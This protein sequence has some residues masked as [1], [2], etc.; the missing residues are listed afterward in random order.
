MKSKL[1]RLHNINHAAYRCRDAEQTRWFYQEVLGL[2]M[3]I[4]VVEDTV[5]GEGQGAET[6]FMH[7]FFELGDNN[8]VAFFD[9]P[10]TAT[11]EDFK[12]VHSFDRHIAYEVGSREE[13]LAWAKHI[14]EHGVEVFG[15]HNHGFVE[16]IYF[17]D[18]NGMQE[19][20]TYRTPEFDQ[21]S[22]HE[23]KNVDSNLSQWTERY[24]A[25]K[26]AKFGADALDK[27][28]VEYCHELYEKEPIT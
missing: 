19:E 21:I 9:E 4:A 6:P 18:P 22:T 12:P 1:V 2:P 15:P 24:R 17:Y 16:S 5:P 14:S 20:I 10:L 3:T 28:M 7:L 26:E 25:L 11:P 23:R 13:L 8:F 27:R